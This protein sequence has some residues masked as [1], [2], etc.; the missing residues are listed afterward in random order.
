MGCSRY[1]ESSLAIRAVIVLS[2]RAI[3]AQTQG[4]PHR[5]SPR[6]WV[7]GI[8]LHVLV[9]A[10]W[11]FPTAWLSARAYLGNPVLMRPAS[12]TVVEFTPLYGVNDGS[13]D[14]TVSLANTGVVSSLPFTLSIPLADLA[15]LASDPRD[16]RDCP[17]VCPSSIVIAGSAPVLPEFISEVPRT[18]LQDLQAQVNK[19]ESFVHNTIR[20]ELGASRAAIT[21][22]HWAQRAMAESE[23]GL[24]EWQQA[25]ESLRGHN[26][27]W[28]II[29]KPSGSNS[30]RTGTGLEV[31]DEDGEV[32]ARGHDA[33]L[34]VLRRKKEKRKAKG[35]KKRNVEESSPE[36]PELP[37]GDEERPRRIR[38]RRRDPGSET[39]EFPRGPVAGPSGV[40]RDDKGEKLGEEKDGEGGDEGSGSEWGGLGGGSWQPEGPEDSGNVGFNA[41]FA[42]TPRVE[43]PNI[44]DISHLPRLNTQ[45]PVRAKP[46]PLTP[47]PEPA[48]TPMPL[49]P[50]TQETPAGGVEGNE[51]GPEGDRMDVEVPEGTGEDR[52]VGWNSINIIPDIVPDGCR[53]GMVVDEKGKVRVQYELEDD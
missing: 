26:L 29:V 37:R 20:P 40:R 7:D 25:A 3:V 34:E 22:D 47:K 4:P 43:M 44:V 6:P 15:D 36:R 35:K 14:D 28:K 11:L 27:P 13:P 9:P 38:R 32:V 45:G 10:N 33:F 31:V 12:A 30:I 46:K 51:T 39:D 21:W 52:P 8:L 5:L 53:A 23:P 49:A 24:E 41:G 48:D 1:Y 18:R 19:L 2:L 17:A 50:S 16:G 42:F